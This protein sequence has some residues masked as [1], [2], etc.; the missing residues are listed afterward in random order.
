MVKATLLGEASPLKDVYDCVLAYVAGD[1]ASLSTQM[2]KLQLDE[3]EVPRRY[4]EAVA[5]AQQAL[6]AGDSTNDQPQRAPALARS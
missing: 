2:D 4:R 3:E 6:C 5:W 1:W